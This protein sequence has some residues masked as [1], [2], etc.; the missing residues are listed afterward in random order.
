M[1]ILPVNIVTR[2]FILLAN[3]IEPV[4]AQGVKAA[5]LV[6]ID[7]SALQQDMFFVSRCKTDSTKV[8]QSS[9]AG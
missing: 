3:A 6:K 7:L 1:L 9:T 4:Q 2:L 8:N 5:I